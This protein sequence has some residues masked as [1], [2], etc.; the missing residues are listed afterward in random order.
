MAQES[1]SVAPSSR[2]D[3]ALERALAAARVAAENRGR[4][5][6]ILD[7]RELTTEFDYFV[8]VTGASRRQLH[9]VSDE[10]DHLFER[11]WNDQRLG[12]EGY[13]L[14]RWILLDYGDIVVHMFDDDAR[15]YYDLDQLWCQAKRVPFEP[16]PAA[17]AI[18]SRPTNDDQ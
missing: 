15:K 1:S 16:P 9:A 13:N 10:I 6:V 17:P 4:D 11:T 5:I 8:L 3:R 7:L 2:S 12:I 14:S 18:M